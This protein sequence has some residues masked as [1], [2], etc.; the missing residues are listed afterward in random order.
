[1]AKKGATVALQIDVTN[2]E[3]WEKIKTE[4][5]GV[6]L[7]D[8]YTEWCG[9]CVG[10]C[11]NLRKVKLEVGGENITY[12]T[13]K[14][15]AIEELQ[16]FRKKSEP[17]W[18]FIVEGRMTN[19]MFGPD[20]PRLMRM[21]V[22]EVKKEQDVQA[23]LKER[24]SMPITSI[25]PE[26]KKRFAELEE[27]HGAAIRLEQELLK[28]KQDEYRM[29]V[30]VAVSEGLPDHS[31]LI[32]WPHALD[33][34]S[35]IMDHCEELQLQIVTFEKIV[36]ENTVIDECFFGA[37]PFHPAALRVLSKGLSMIILLQTKEEFT[38]SSIE[39]ALISIIESGLGDRFILEYT[40][41]KLEEP[42][43]LELMGEGYGEE[44]TQPYE[45]ITAA[46]P[47]PSDVST[48]APSDSDVDEVLKASYP[49]MMGE[50]GQFVKTSPD[51]SQKHADRMS[52]GDYS[53]DESYVEEEY[54]VHE[55]EPILIA[56]IYT[57][58]NNIARGSALAALFP[59]VA[60]EYIPQPPSSIPPHVAIIFDAFKKK[61]VMDMVKENVAY[62]MNMGVFTSANPSTAELIAKSIKEYEQQRPQPG[63][64]IVVMVMK[65]PSAGL[66]SLAQL[67]PVYVS[68]NAEIGE[69]ECKKFFPPGYSEGPF[70]LEED[71]EKEVVEETK[72]KKKKKQKKTEEKVEEK[73][74]EAAGEEPKEGEAKPAEGGEGGE[75]PAEGAAEGTAVQGEEKP[76]TEN[77]AITAAPEEA[78]A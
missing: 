70:T 18:M 68:P 13:A 63:Q 10:M 51:A 36:L 27:L 30:A 46:A 65:K 74:E 55:E 50:W 77:E 49:E 32:L 44:E 8:V 11:G 72:T 42:P 9:P 7:I 61:D 33:A 2:E 35:N 54:A 23:G 26:E 5:K 34:L 1:M 73:V 31:V 19:L 40:G 25:A 22:Q 24:V 15:D 20:A 66:L 43:E 37:E 76:A 21:I 62:I 48:S 59:S 58:T 29:E 75:Q 47:A 53:R 67:G 60:A 78:P 56:G 3:D 41:E 12:V 38:M 45:A 64:K 6:I 57:P 52:Q 69:V 39:E 17:T 14:A 28:K 71:V 4:K 16:R